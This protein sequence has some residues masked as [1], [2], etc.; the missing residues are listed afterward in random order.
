MILFSD[1]N[2]LSVFERSAIRVGP[3][4]WLEGVA[5]PCSSLI[6]ETAAASAAHVGIYGLALLCDLGAALCVHSDLGRDA[7]GARFTNNRPT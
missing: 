5:L 4:T 3:E 2:R 1:D 7:T 6:R